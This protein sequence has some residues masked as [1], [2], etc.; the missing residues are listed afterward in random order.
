MSVTGEDVR[1]ARFDY[2]TFGVRGYSELEV[3]VFLDRVA[4]TLDGT[5]DGEDELTARDVHDVAFSRV[6]PGKRGY[7][8][9][10]VDAFLRLVESTLAVREASGTGTGT[11]R[12]Y[13]APALEHTHA[14]RGFWQWIRP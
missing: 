12:P 4:A 14:R 9:A 6:A 7:D 2:A 5:C 13:I 10:A 8:P 11:T 3:V 1:N